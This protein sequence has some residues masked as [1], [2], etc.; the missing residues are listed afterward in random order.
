MA[1]TIPNG[2]TP[3]AFIP[4]VPTKGEVEKH[5]INLNAFVDSIS[6]NYSPQWS[7]HMD[8][9]RAD[10]KMMYNQFSR[11]VS[12]EF[13]IM[14][15]QNE[16]HHLN[17]KKMNSLASLTYPIYKRGKGFNGIYVRMYL[18][19]FISGIGIITSLS[20]SVD[21]ESPWIDKIPLYIQCSMDIKLIGRYKPD[22]RKPEDDGPYGHT[23]QY[24]K[25]E[26]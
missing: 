17:M 7:E 21:N 2:G 16:E 25:G 23:N 6:D 14:A 3:F 22:Y 24:I 9:G 4:I 1:S 15:L 13:K 18:G 8:M 11:N 5:K 12:I 26:K 19:K 10:P 20:F